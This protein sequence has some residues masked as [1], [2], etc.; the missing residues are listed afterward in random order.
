MSEN[1]RTHVGGDPQLST[2]RNPDSVLRGPYAQRA[3]KAVLEIAD[4][5]E[6]SA[7]WE[8]MAPDLSGWL[9]GSILLSRY[10]QLVKP[11]GE[12]QS[13]IE[14]L[15]ELVTEAAHGFDPCRPYPLSLYQ[16]ITGLGWLLT[17]IAKLDGY[18]ADVTSLDELLVRR[19]GHPWEGDYDL[20]RGLVGIGIYAIERIESG[21]PKDLLELVVHQLGKRAVRDPNGVA[22]HTDRALLF[23]RTASEYPTGYYNLGLAHGVPG[24]LRLL[25]DAVRLGV[26][27]E[28]ASSL[29]C[30]ATPWLLSHLIKT[31]RG[32]TLRS[33][34]EKRV[35][36]R[37]RLAWCYNELGAMTS[38]LSAGR[39]LGRSDWIDIAHQVFLS[40]ADT[41]PELSGV[42]D[43][44]LCHGSAGVAH[45][46]RV[47]GNDLEDLTLQAAAKGWFQETIHRQRPGTGVGGY[48]ARLMATDQGTR[49]ERYKDV[50]LPGFLEG[51]AGVGLALLCELEQLV[52][53]WNRVLG[54]S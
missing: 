54:L 24:V 41:P 22:W 43:A 27:S 7:L 36:P 50:P 32:W 40:I 16:G 48:S 38:I 53:A 25:T 8:H 9:G 20:I 39:V 30:G 6:D 4:A 44:G 2:P 13:R 21:E 1:K 14:V 42:V 34:V 29:V 10:L 51:S 5:V 46:L 12:R 15:L 17:H 37:V 47:V 45:I 49:G 31:D 18:K 11:N 3:W 23:G 35:T 33:I 28:L 26:Q 52:P 19:L